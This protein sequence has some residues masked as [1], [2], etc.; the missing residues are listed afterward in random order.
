MGAFNFNSNAGVGI[1]E[2]ENEDYCFEDYLSEKEVSKLSSDIGYKVYLKILEYADNNNIDIKE[3]NTGTFDDI[4]KV[5]YGYYSGFK[6]YVDYDEIEKQ[7]TDKF[8]DEADYKLREKYGFDSFMYSRVDFEE[9][10]QAEL[11]EL[12]QIKD[13]LYEMACEYSIKLLYEFGLEKGFNE[14]LTA[15]WC[16]HNEPIT[17]EMIA[18]KF[19]FNEESLKSARKRR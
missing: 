18:E 8:E 10:A 16:S 9:K 6:L 1:Y 12:S 2:Y 14:V 11:K 17:K 4:I 13:K 19:G 3:L 5:E 7:I 15:N